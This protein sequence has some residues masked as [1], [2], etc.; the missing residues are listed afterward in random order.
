MIPISLPYIYK[1]AT[2]LQRLTTIQHDKPLKDAMWIL[3]RAEQ[4]LGEFL[5]NSVYSRNDNLKTSTTVGNVLLSAIKKLT[6]ESDKE[7]NLD[8]YDVY[9]VTNA[10]D[11]FETVLAAEMDTGTAFLVTKKR[12]YDTTDL[13]FRAEV[14]F[15]P[16]LPGKVPESLPEIREAGKCIAFEMGTAAGFHIMRATELVLRRYYDVVMEGDNRPKNDNLGGYLRAMEEKPAGDPKVIAAMKQITSLHR[17]PLMHPEDILTLDEAIGL[18]GMA[19]SV[20]VAMLDELPE[21]IPP[22]Q[23]LPTTPIQP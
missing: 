11:K 13:I 21:I 20:M 7:R 12:G 2:D 23:L 17:N 16:E 3:Y 9:S 8:F 5:T 22:P 10:L 1:V 18:M 4:T 6:T 14:L 19:Q 15:P